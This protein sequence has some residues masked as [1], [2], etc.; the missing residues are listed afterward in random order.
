MHQGAQD[1]DP[2]GIL[3]PRDVAGS[4]TE[5]DSTEDETSDDEALQLAEALNQPGGQP[6]V[7]APV[8][9]GTVATAVTRQLDLEARAEAAEALRRAPGIMKLIEA[10]IFKFDDFLTKD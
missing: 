10:R 4:E 5:S 3:R 9:P 6:P 8:Q 2:S 1:A 7:S